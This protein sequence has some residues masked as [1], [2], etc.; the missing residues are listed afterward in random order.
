[1]DWGHVKDQGNILVIVDA[2]SGW[3]EAFPAGNRN[4]QTVKMCLSQVLARLGIPRTLVSDNG[5]DFVSGD[6]KQWCESLG[7]KKMESPV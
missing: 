4:S 3:T 2:G 5:P 1:M 6:L 7:I